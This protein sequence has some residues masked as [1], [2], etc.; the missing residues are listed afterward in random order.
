MEDILRN[1]L[2]AL[3]EQPQP[4]SLVVLP[5]VL[6]DP[7]YRAGI[8]KNV[9][10]PAVLDF[11]QNTF[12]RWTTSFR[13]EAI[14]P[15][16]NKVRAF[17]TDPLLRAIIGQP[18][19]SFDF[20]W[21][22][23][24]RKVILCDV[25]KGEIG[26]DNAILLGSLIVMQEKLAALS[27][28]DTPESDRVPHLLFAEEAQNFIGDFESILSETRKFSLIL[29][30]ATQGIDSL[31]RQMAAAI[32]T[33]AANLIAF[34]VSNTDAER[35]QNE[36]AMAIPGTFIQDLPDYKAYVRTLA[37][38]D[39]GCRPTQPEQIATYP[40]FLRN[41]DAEWRSK[42][43]RTS[44]ERYTRSRSSIDTEITRILLRCRQSA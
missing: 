33:N 4:T 44:S 40:P 42:V 31:S 43:E 36:F 5:T 15:V 3:I 17:T 26:S 27:R 12:D 25:S 20:R 41:R 8:L 37:C 22:L 2:Y 9:T 35:L 24:C 14:S 28:S 34:R 18:R 39:A 29:A 11:F 19:S 13:E 16:L 30:I 7:A 38:D 21:A 10:N 32:F 1:A 23:D 6:T